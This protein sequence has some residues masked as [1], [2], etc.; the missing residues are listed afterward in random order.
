MTVLNQIHTQ[1]LLEYSRHSLNIKYA[2]TL[3]FFISTSSRAPC[4]YL[5]IPPRNLDP[6][7]IFIHRK[8]ESNHHPLP[9]TSSFCWHAHQNPWLKLLI[10]LTGWITFLHFMSLYQPCVVLNL[11]HF[12]LVFLGFLYPWVPSGII[13]NPS[14]W[15]APNLL[16]FPFINKPHV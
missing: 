8:N 12:L 11:V 4:L 1:P 5:E 7:V 6:V 16:A 10:P 15:H 3:F 2:M 14:D 9:D 13:L